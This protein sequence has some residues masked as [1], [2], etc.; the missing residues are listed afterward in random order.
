LEADA[1]EL[2]ALASGRRG[3]VPLTSVLCVA[4]VAGGSSRIF[5]MLALIS[6]LAL[7][8]S[9]GEAD[10]GEGAIVL[11]V[12]TFVVD[13]GLVERDAVVVDREGGFE[14]NVELESAREP[15]GKGFGRG[16]LAL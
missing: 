5:S 10:G 2:M 1:A 14:F 11:D 9:R 15:D 7:S 3:P 12:R 16:G 6:G 13:E 8:T 4:R